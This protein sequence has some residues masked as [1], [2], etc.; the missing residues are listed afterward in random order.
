[1]VRASSTLKIDRRVVIRA[2]NGVP[3]NAPSRTGG[4]LGTSHLSTWR[5]FRKMS[6]VTVMLGYN[7]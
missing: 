2:P 7:M 3:Q 4:K 1:M 6:R 5:F